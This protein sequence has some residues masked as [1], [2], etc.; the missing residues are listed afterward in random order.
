[1]N[2]YNVL[3]RIKINVLNNKTGFK[4]KQNIIILMTASGLV[5][6]VRGD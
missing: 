2:D 5:F 6:V 1:M 3:D 4:N